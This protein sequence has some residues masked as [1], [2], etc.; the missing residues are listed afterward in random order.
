VLLHAADQ[1][2]DAVVAG[3]DELLRQSII[4]E[5]DADTYDFSHDKIRE[6]VYTQI[7]ATRRRLLHRRVA[8]AL[9]QIHAA[10]I[11]QVSGQL[12]AHYEHGG[13]TAQAVFYY[14]Q[15]AL[16]ARQVYAN[17]E[18]IEHYKR[19]LTLLASMPDTLDRSRQQLTFLIELG[20]TLVTAWGYGLS[21]VYDIY[22][23][24]QVLA[25]QLGEPP[26][27]AIL[28]ALAIYHIA[29][30]QY[31]QAY[32]LG[33]QIE[34]LAYQGH[35]RVDP[36]LF[37]ESRYVMGAAIFWPGKFL[38]AHNHFAQGVA[39]YDVR[40]HK[41]HIA[42]FSQDPGVVCSIRLAQALWCL[43]YPDQARQQYEAA[44]ALARQL[45]HPLTLAYALIFAAWVSDDRRD[46]T[47]TSVFSEEII[48]LSRTYD[49]PYF[50]FMGLAFQG[51]MLA[52]H[53]ETAAG[54]TQLRASISG[55]QS[56]QSYVHLSQCLFMLAQAY[57][58][59]NQIDLAQATLDEGL[60]A[61]THHGDYYCAAEYYRLKGELLDRSGTVPSIVEACFQQAY[62]IARDQ[63]AKLFELRAT[64]SLS[65]LWQQQG[66]H[67]EAH[68][69]L[70][71]IYG[72]FT[73]GFDTVDLKEARAL[74]EELA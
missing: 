69:I 3:L 31:V 30:R 12:A 9:E 33:E 16:Q 42:L 67:S 23:Q 11:D 19:G 72:W 57:M 7:S 4:R 55:Y 51:H 36:V 17:H 70:C 20:S 68:Q 24:A 65:R 1:S 45:A 61:I 46:D 43:G 66:K 73:E 58:Q 28:R 34:A 59:A 35:D 54:I 64:V 74:L 39:D 60:S 44:L 10:R 6:V 37:M 2:E 8:Q 32:A 47:T 52:E 21:Q 18:A 29:R 26:N 14:R 48:A 5:Q 40:H 25:Q 53:G 56:I 41:T 50:L 62:A 27:P 49:M 15:A 38:Q 63:H 71:E 22:S 13:M